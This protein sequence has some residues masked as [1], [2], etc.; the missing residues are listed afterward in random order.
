[1]ANPTTVYLVRHGETEWNLAGRQQGHLDSPLTPRGIRQANAL[2]HALADRGIQ[3]I[4]AS[5]LGR[6]MQTAETIAANLNLPVHPDP[7][8]RERHLGTMQAL[9]K[10]QFQQQHPQAS[11]AFDSGDPDHC[12]PGGESAR[13]RYDRTVSCV[14]ELAQHQPGQTM[15]IV[16]HGGVLDGMCRR[17]LAIP[18]TQPRRFSL[19]NGAVNRFTWTDPNWQ[20]DTWGD[21]TH[22]GDLETLDDN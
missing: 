2:A 20:L 6:A 8:L 22:L 21:L 3:V 9:T 18:L 15:L 12:L 4:Y 16:T 17:T 1:M 10:A 19:F 7:R 11:A 5:D 14:E 13:Q